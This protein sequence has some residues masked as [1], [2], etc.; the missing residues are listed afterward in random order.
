MSLAP[1][2]LEQI[3]L[4]LAHQMDL[5]TLRDWI[6]EH[7]PDV[8]P[9]LDSQTQ[10][11]FAATWQFLSDLD[12]GFIDEDRVRVGLT[13]VHGAHEPPLAV[14]GNPGYETLAHYPV[15]GLRFASEFGERPL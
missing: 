8:V 13:H 6:A 2:Y 7:E 1:A 10:R 12:D 11:L 9:E 4:Y 15:T 3:R 14:A 5:G